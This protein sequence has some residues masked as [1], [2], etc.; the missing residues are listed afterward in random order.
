EGGGAMITLE[1]IY[2]LMGVMLAGITLVSARDRTNR[3]RWKN[4]A[5]WGMYAATF[6]FGSYL[7]HLAS[8]A[9]VIAMAAVSGVGGLGKGDP[10]TTTQAERAES[11]GRLR[12]RLYVPALL[13]PGL[14][15]LGTL[16]LKNA[17]LHGTPLVDVKQVTV[18]SLGIATLVAL[19]AAVAMLR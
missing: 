18:I 17:T 9:L 11:A 13:I 6:L 2:L 7:P 15:L 8:G 16:T 1:F 10:D 4:T 14:T 3:K 12:N 5:F 19:A